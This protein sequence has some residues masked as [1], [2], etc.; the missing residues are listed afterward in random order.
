MLYF[1]SIGCTP[2]TAMNPADFLIDLANGN[3]SD[4]SFPTDLDDKVAVENIK[5]RHGTRAKPSEI[6]EVNNLSSSLAFYMVASFIV[7]F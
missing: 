4:K 3:I 1:S 5:V 2:L 6:H 7:V